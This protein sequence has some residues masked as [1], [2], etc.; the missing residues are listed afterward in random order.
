[1]YPGQVSKLAEDPVTASSTTIAPLSDLVVVSGTVAIAT[2]TPPLGTNV[3]QRVTL[4][5]TGAWTLVTTGNIAVAATAVVSRA[6]TMFWSKSQQKW[7]P[8]Y[9]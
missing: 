9:V 5:P 6:M 3:S 4:V 2:I 7:Y 1:M 8:S